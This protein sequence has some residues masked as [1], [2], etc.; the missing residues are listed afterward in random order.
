[1]DMETHSDDSSIFGDMTSVFG[2]QP[3]NQPDNQRKRKREQDEE[4]YDQIHA[5][6]TL[7][8]QEF[9]A[10]DGTITPRNQC[11]FCTY[12]DYEHKEVN[13]EIIKYGYPEIPDDE[14]KQIITEIDN[15]RIS[16]LQIQCK[17]TATRYNEYIAA[18]LN[19][20]YAYDP[21]IKPLPLITGSTVESHFVHHESSPKAKLMTSYNNL[22][23]LGN[24]MIKNKAFVK[25]CKDGKIKYDATN[26]KS[27]TSI[28][29]TQS[30]ILK[31]L[32]K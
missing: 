31:V 28:V 23:I 16:F 6:M 10:S 5:D 14:I 17:I 7:I 30:E 18:D 26:I 27:Y 25:R 21:T 3:G 24:D 19:S 29:K 9:L 2:N 4:E 11:I 20:K 12:K 8:N 22:A 32:E 13:G 1:M 15:S